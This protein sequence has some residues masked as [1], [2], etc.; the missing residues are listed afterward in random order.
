MRIPIRR[1]PTDCS[2]SAGQ[3][4]SGICL[5]GEAG[6]GAESYRL[7]HYQAAFGPLLYG[8]GLAIAWTMF[9]RE[10]EPAVRQAALVEREVT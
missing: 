8:V 10:T 9:L 7:E 1:A 5:L 3:S 2:T 4:G 6:G